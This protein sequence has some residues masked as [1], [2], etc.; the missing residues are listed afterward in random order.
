MSNNAGGPR[1]SQGV[2]GWPSGIHTACCGLK[3]ILNSD[4]E[5]T[6]AL[7]SFLSLASSFLLQVCVSVLEPMSPTCNAGDLG[8]IPGSARSLGEGEMA[9][10]SSILAWETPW[11]EEPGGLQSMGL[12][13]VG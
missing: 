8:L 5:H 4:L 1:C 10:H 7:F 3:A 9:T 12:Q 11:M 6:P 13:R 2:S